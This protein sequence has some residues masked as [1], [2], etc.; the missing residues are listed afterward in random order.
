MSATH[1]CGV[2]ALLG[3]PNAGKST[4]L[5][6]LLGQKLAITAARA[7]T[8]RS[9]LLGIDTRPGA[10]ILYYDTPGAAALDNL[11]DWTDLYGGPWSGLVV[12]PKPGLDEAIVLT[13]WNRLLRLGPFDADAAA[14]FIDEFRGRGPEHP[15]R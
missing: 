8:T 2:V 7:Q 13:A 14:A 9:R 11:K 5:N 15:V 10:Q 6:A 1:R 12:A 4:L 3:R